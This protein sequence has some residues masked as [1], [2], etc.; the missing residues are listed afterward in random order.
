MSQGPNLGEAAVLLSSDEVALDKSPML[1][2]EATT[3][4]ATEAG[5]R[6]AE[7]PCRAQH[8]FPDGAGP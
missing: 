5:L 4:T 6:I 1:A 7:K 8:C 2:A 3:V